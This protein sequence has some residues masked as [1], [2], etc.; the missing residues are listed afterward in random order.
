MQ[1]SLPH[2]LE[3]F[4]EKCFHS[5]SC[6]F[7]IGTFCLNSYAFALFDTQAHDGEDFLQIAFF[8]ALGNRQGR[9]IFLGFFDQ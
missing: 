2:T 4:F 5:R 1:S 3:I 7:F 8:A 9:G 6:S